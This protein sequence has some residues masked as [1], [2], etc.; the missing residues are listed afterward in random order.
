[1]SN[2]GMEH[3]SFLV[4]IV[5]NGVPVPAMIDCAVNTS[6]CLALTETAFFDQSIL[7]LLYFPDDQK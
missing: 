2:A 3:H 6:L 7:E 5:A 1:M 4:F